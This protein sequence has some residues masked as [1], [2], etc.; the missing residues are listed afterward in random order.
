MDRSGDGKW[1]L[2]LCSLFVLL[3]IQT[4]QIRSEVMGDVGYLRGP[5]NDDSMGCSAVPKLDPS[6]GGTG[7]LSL[8]RVCKALFS[9][10]T[11]LLGLGKV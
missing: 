3:N 8:H 7:S 2:D 5:R 4:C 6:P 10:S 1:L 11:S 9:F